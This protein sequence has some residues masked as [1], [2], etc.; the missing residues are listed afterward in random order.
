MGEV[1]DVDTIGTA[2]AEGANSRWGYDAGFYG[3]GPEGWSD[4]NDLGGEVAGYPFHDPKEPSSW[5]MG[6]FKTKS[7]ELI[8]AVRH[9]GKEGS[10]ESE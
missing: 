5:A 3:S 2:G 8:D 9:P 10:H 1:V 7:M 4:G 6:G